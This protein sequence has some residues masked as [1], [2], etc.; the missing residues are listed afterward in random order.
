MTWMETA[1]YRILDVN[2]NR[3]RE[4]L[5][6]VEEYFRFVR[7]DSRGSWRLKQWR[8]EF[9]WMVEVLGSEK[10][11]SA[12]AAGSDVGKDLTSPS[13][14]SKIDPIAITAAGLKRLQESLRV[15][16]EYA[17]GVNSEVSLRAGKMRFEVYQF[18]KEL[19]L[20]SP[21]Q[22]FERVRLYLLIGTDF[23]S[24]EAMPE[25]AS[26]LRDAGVDCLQLREKKLKDG[27]LLKLADR[28]AEICRSKEKIFIV[29]DRADIARMV[30]A[31][32]VHVGQEDLPVDAVRQVLGEDRIIGVSTHNMTQLQEAVKRN[33]AYIAI[34]PAF[35]TTTK[36]HEPVVGLEYIE[37]AVRTLREVGIPEV[38]IGG[39]TLGNLSALRE[40]GVV[41]IALCGAILSS[42]DPVLTTRKF[43]ELLRSGSLK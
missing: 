14:A 39:I 28:L 7:E 32:G 16:E 11:L 30:G 19:F 43:S 10:L 12:R 8:H 35:S 17:S 26:R 31:D 37:P 41:R 9:R 34:G 24:L 18:E 36:P 25:L 22:R 4:G 3:A 40:Q 15:I 20:I 27:E 6:V 21:R 42:D 1:I 13:Q 2:L 23:C 5:R 29:N 38:A 33:P